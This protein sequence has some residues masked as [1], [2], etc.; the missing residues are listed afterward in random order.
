MGLFDWLRSKTTVSRRTAPQVVPTVQ[1]WKRALGMFGVALRLRTGRTL[2]GLGPV[3]LTNVQFVSPSEL[4][5]LAKDLSD[6]KNP[7]EELER[8]KAVIAL[9][10]F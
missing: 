2:E 5:Q 10:N 9:K 6:A 7:N 3:Y 4:M 8:V 1:D